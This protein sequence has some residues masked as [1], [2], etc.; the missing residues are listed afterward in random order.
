MKK[1][2]VVELYEFNKHTA[3]LYRQGDKVA[4]RFPLRERRSS[5]FAEDARAVLAGRG[6]EQEWEVIEVD[7]LS[8]R[9]WDWIFGELIAEWRNG[10]VHEKSKGDGDVWWYSW[11]S[12]R[13]AEFVQRRGE[14][15]PR[16]PSKRRFPKEDGGLVA[17][18]VI[19]MTLLTR[20]TH[21]AVMAT[22]VGPGTWGGRLAELLEPYE[23][24]NT[25]EVVSPVPARFVDQLDRMSALTEELWA[26]AG[27]LAATVLQ[28]MGYEYDAPV[29]TAQ[30]AR[31]L[32]RALRDVSL[33]MY[34]WPRAG[35]AAWEALSAM[36]ADLA[37]RRARAEAS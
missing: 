6:A 25:G 27:D 35:S 36:T 23:D 11:G 16:G 31:D 14:W 12:H 15:V 13:A 24:V 22:L 30:V 4:Y 2:N 1:N 19:L 17:A 3:V 7:K 21:A 28:S 32:R 33:E 10:K 18:H 37:E 9:Q 26:A 34:E 8:E 29:E 20:E 5:E